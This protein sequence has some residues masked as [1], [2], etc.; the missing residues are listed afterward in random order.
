MKYPTRLADTIHLLAAIQILR[1]ISGPG[2]P[3]L[4]LALKSGEL[5]RRMGTNPAHLRKLMRLAA[6]GGLLVSEKGKV[7][8]RLARPAREISLLDIFHA[9]EGEN[10]VFTLHQRPELTCPVGRA[11]DCALGEACAEIENAAASALAK[12]S[13]QRIIDDSYARE[14]QPGRTGPEP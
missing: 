3:E 9:V 8:P 13:L 11:I 1:E 4:K 10:S 6:A 7:N 5:A 2:A 14:W 12:I